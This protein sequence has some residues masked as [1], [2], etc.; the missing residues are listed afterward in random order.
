MDFDLIVLWE[1]KLEELLAM[2]ETQEMGFKEHKMW[3]CSVE[4]TQIYQ[5]R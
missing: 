5:H 4:M 2:V 3:P 1:V